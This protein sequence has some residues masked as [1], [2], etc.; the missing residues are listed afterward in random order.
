MKLFFEIHNFFANQFDRLY[1]FKIPALSNYA[2]SGEI[3]GPFSALIIFF[4]TLKNNQKA[5]NNDKMKNM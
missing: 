2:G 5:I 4:E 1:Q 3:L